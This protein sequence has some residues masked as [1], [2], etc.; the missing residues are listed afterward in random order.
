MAL[1]KR[2]EKYSLTII[3]I[4]IALIFIYEGYIKLLSPNNLITLFDSWNFILPGVIAWTIIL[5]E[6]IF[7]IMVL[8]GFKVKYTAWPLIILL[9]I[10]TIVIVIP[11]GSIT[12][13]LF[14]V[15]GLA[16]LIS[17]VLRGGGKFSIS[18]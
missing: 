16:V 11:F 9:T 13:I 15:L 10:F 18:K 14:H 3:R 7:G 17:L 12:T 1:A 8:V 5:T 4:P 6:L 2:L